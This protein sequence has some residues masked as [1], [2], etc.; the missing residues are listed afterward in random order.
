MD[1]TQPAVVAPISAILVGTRRGEM[2]WVP[3]V[4]VARSTW[5]VGTRSGME[6]KVRLASVTWLVGTRSGELVAGVPETR[7][8]SIVIVG[9]R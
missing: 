5:T 7:A 8:T 9:M 3:R 4:S 2:V 1:T 6:V